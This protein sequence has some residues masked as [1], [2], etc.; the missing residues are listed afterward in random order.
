MNNVLSK[1]IDSLPP[2]PKTIIE[3]EEFKKSSNKDLNKL[4]E[5]VNQDPLIVATLLKVSNS[6]MFGFNNKVETASRALHLLG[7]NFTLSI[8]F[9]SAIKNSFDTELKAYNINSDGFLRLANMSSNLLSNW[10]GKIDPE[11]RDELLLPSFLLETGRFVLS[12]IAV[13]NKQEKKFYTRLQT[14]SS[15]ISKLEKEFF[16]ATSTQVTSSIFKY[17]NLSDNLINIIK[18]TDDIDSCPQEYL[19]KA[20]ILTVVKT[21]CNVIEPLSDKSIEEGVSLASNFG[22]DTRHLKK[23]IEKMEDRLLEEE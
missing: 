13:D 18:Y 9:G 17:W 8:A 5:I 1:K 20:K 10:I 2:L 21:I 15:S 16:E 23:A 7:I 4:L 6:A 22:L 12:S 19:E 14:D 11:L 3:L